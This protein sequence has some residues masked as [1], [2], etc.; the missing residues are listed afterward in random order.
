[1]FVPRLLFVLLL[2]LTPP[3][4][5]QPAPAPD[6]PLL[7][8][9]HAYDI[10]AA[11]DQ[12]LRIAFLEVRKAELLPLSALTRMA[13]SLGG[14]YQYDRTGRS[15]LG[16]GTSTGSVFLEQPLLDLSV[17]P[18]RKRGKIAAEA[19][20]LSRNFTIR[21]TLFGVTSAYFDVLKSERQVAV[22]Q[23]SLD[24]AK[25]QEELAQKRANIGEVTRTDVLRAKVSLE[26]S[27]RNLITSE[28]T[29]E[30]KRNTL[31][32]VLNM[33]PDAPFRVA[34][35]LPYRT[36]VPEFPA[37]L[38]KAY[39][40]REDLRESTLAVQQ[41]E[42]RRDEFRTQYAPSIVAR[43][44]SQ[45][46]APRS[47]RPETWDASISVQVPFFTGGQRE[48]DIV[49]AGRDMEK[50]ALQRELL[51]EK[52]ESEVKQACL[53]VE[54]LEG[55]LSAVRAQVAAAEQSYKD[56][57]NQYSAGTARSV[58]VLSGLQDLSTARLDLTSLSLDYQV[59]LRALERVAGTFQD[60][61]VKAAARK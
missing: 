3:A 20:R 31:R 16:P 37:L 38:S 51:L 18:A 35:P 26:V 58:D 60:L 1:M 52:I 43:G 2:L 19:S 48:I 24:L 9:E 21:E 40:Q 49:N 17:F 46:P 11:S 50:A 4:H 41:A 56:L 25:E 12:T 36:T 44:S 23:Q 14:S 42:L 54:T 10:A 59:A 39:A 32:N 29:L 55:S 61:R 45:F 8:L 33:K 13:P 6:S 57:Q 30:F 7:T 34:E 47:N 22:N 5:A 28:N 53:N 15:L 27:R